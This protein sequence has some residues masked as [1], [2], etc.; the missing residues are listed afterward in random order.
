MIC[1]VSSLILTAAVSDM[2]VFLAA[3]PVLALHGCAITG[4]L[5]QE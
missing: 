3:S 5:L 4:Q 1:L 2:S